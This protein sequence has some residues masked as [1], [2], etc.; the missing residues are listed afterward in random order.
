MCPHNLDGL[1]FCFRVIVCQ[2][3]SDRAGP[4]AGGRIKRPL[5]TGGGPHST[6]V[7]TSCGTT[8]SQQPPVL[9]PHSATFVSYSRNGGGSSGRAQVCASRGTQTWNISRIKCNGKTGKFC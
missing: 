1:L 5:I 2:K 4:P 9:F 6:C 7:G 3:S 8:A